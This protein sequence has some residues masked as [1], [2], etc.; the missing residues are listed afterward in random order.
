MGGMGAGGLQR[1]SL[2]ACAAVRAA[3]EA[4][5]EGWECAGLSR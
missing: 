5:E 1:V 2:R 3:A 4:G